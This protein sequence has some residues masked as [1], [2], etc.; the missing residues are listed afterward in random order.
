MDNTGEGLA[1][2]LRSG[3]AGA[4]TAVDHITVLDAALAQIPDAYRH[5]TDLLMR[6]DSA[7]GAKAFLHHIRAL[8][9]RGIHTFFSVGYPVTE[10][11]SP[12]PGSARPPV[13][14]RAGA[15]RPPADRHASCRVDRHG[16][17]RGLGL[18]PSG[19]LKFSGVRAW[20]RGMLGTVRGPGTLRRTLLDLQ[21]RARAEHDSPEGRRTYAVRSASGARSTN[22]HTVTGC[23]GYRG[24]EKTHVPPVQSVGRSVRRNRIAATMYRM[25]PRGVRG[26]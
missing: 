1:G 13:A 5:G 3:N 26:S 20:F 14:S 15:G 4:S 8:R 21:R 10:P 2:L 25:R 12:D 23:G 7:G 9:E 11:V 24:L 18:T 22:W 16:Q 17:T 6:T 19:I